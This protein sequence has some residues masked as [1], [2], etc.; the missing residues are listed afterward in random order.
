MFHETVY[1]KI[2]RGLSCALHCPPA[3]RRFTRNRLTYHHEANVRQTASELS[4]PLWALARLVGGKPEDR[5]VGAG[6][7][8]RRTQIYRARNDL[9]L[10]AKVL[11]KQTLLKLCLRASCIRAPER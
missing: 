11:T 8:R 6:I 4:E 9:C 7:D 5:T 1:F 3:F 2:R 10:D